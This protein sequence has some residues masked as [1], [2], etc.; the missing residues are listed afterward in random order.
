MNYLGLCNE[1]AS[2]ADTGVRKKSDELL[3][4]CQCER[5][6]YAHLFV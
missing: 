4:N 6:R 3:W 1:A 2:D 5:N